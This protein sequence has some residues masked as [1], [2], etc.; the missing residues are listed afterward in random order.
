[1][2]IF[3]IALPAEH[4]LV[5]IFDRLIHSLLEGIAGTEFRLEHPSVP[6]PVS[7]ED[8][9]SFHLV[10]IQS[11]VCRVTPVRQDVCS[12]LILGC[13]RERVL[14]APLIVIADG[15]CCLDIVRNILC[16][17]SEHGS[18]ISVHNRIAAGLL[19]SCIRIPAFNRP[20][21]PAPDDFSGLI[22]GCDY[23]IT[24]NECLRGLEI[25]E[26]VNFVIHHASRSYRAGIDKTVLSFRYAVP[27]ELGGRRRQACVI[28]L[29]ACFS[30]EIPGE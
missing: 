22:Q 25:D 19:G 14:T 3:S 10:L 29:R 8:L 4:P 2:R 15:T 24:V 18:E 16:G 20:D 11:R 26:A 21:I 9:V 28:V 5:R 1:M 30:V 13:C 27:Q 6:G 23:C 12:C 17:K 7:G